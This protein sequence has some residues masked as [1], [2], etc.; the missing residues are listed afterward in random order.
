MDPRFPGL[1]IYS[2][3]NCERKASPN[4]PDKIPTI[5]ISKM[6][7]LLFVALLG[8]LVHGHPTNRIIGGE[9]CVAHSQPW[10]SSI[11]YFSE[12]VCGGT[13]IDSN[14]VLTAAHCNLPS[15]QVRLGEH[16][17]LVYEEREQFN[18]AGK[19]CPHKDFNSDTYEN[20][21]MLLKLATPAN[22]NAYVQTIPL[23]S[24]DV[25]QNTKCL[26]SGWGTTSSPTATFPDILQCVNVQSVS[27]ATCQ[28]AYPDDVINDNM[29]CA[30]VEEGGKDSCQGDSGGPLV[31]N[32]QLHGIT[33]WGNVPCAVAGKPGVYTN[34]SKY[35]KW[36]QD[37]I[38][39]GDCI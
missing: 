4:D 33:S 26:V 30:G 32:S 13:L 37:T 12:H 6:H 25:Q 29:L 17:L 39:N 9:N 27:T 34:V 18:Y 10:Q 22:L 5:L 38:R 16:N 23:A 28:Q 1:I 36:I 8:P 21:I 11:L 3:L 7:V 24:S 31:C 14:W 20:D 15:L 2:N 35:L 19:I